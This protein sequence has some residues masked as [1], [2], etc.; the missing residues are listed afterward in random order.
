M[1]MIKSPKSEIT[2]RILHLI[3]AVRFLAAVIHAAAAVLLTASL[4]DFRDIF[5]NGYVEFSGIF[6]HIC[7]AAIF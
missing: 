5:L 6:H 3:C 4:Y 1:Y 7:T 2:I